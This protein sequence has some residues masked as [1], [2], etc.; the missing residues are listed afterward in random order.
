MFLANLLPRF[1]MIFDPGFARFKRKV[2]D[3]FK[4]DPNYS[5]TKLRRFFRGIARGERIVYHNDCYMVSSY[6]PPQASQPFLTYIKGGTY[7]DQLFT[8]IAYMK[9]AAPLS[10]YLCVTNACHFDCVHC[11]AKNRRGKPSFKTAEWIGLIREIQNAG[12]AMI[13]FTGGEPVLRKD[14]EELISA[15]D[16]RSATILFTSG[17]DFTRERAVSFKKAGLDIL[18]VSLD[19]ADPDTHSYMRNDKKAFQYALN[20][21]RFA[22]DAGLYVLVQPVVFKKELTKEKLFN[23]FRLVHKQGAHE[24]RIHQPVPS[25]IL[26][27]TEDTREIFLTQADREHLFEIQNAANRRL[28][29]FPKVSSFPFTE[30]PEKFG[31]SAGM[32]HAYVTSDGELFPCDFLPLS[33]GNVMEEGFKPVF[34]R[35][36]RQMGIPKERCWTARLAPHI[37]GKTAPTNPETSAKI[38]QCIQASEYPRF[39]ADLQSSN[40]ILPFNN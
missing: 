33:F 37:K 35:M 28:W 21:I 40:D 13:G 29:G 9:R 34:D 30:S 22:R 6:L 32:K 3:L 39:Y 20:A 38:C 24:V 17:K 11:S 1:Q 36:Q 15:V 27:D 5:R 2:H 14:M 26:L 10:T 8:S 16:D 25:G 12:A 31:C 19:S 4:S 7:P 23:L 18:S